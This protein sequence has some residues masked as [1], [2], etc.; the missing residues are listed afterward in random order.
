M[1]WALEPLSTPCQSASVSPHCA[2]VCRLY[3]TMP[4]HAHLQLSRSRNWTC[5]HCNRSNLELLPDPPAKS[6]SS[7]SAAPQ[8]EAAPVESA[9]TLR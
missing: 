4:D 9:S 3:Y 7:E 6:E 2:L 5:P 1:P 8:P